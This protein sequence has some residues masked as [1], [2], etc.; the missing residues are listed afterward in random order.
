VGAAALATQ[1]EGEREAGFTV[2][3][4]EWVPCERGQFPTRQGLR[5]RTDHDVGTSGE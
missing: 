4:K 3:L 2:A 5:H 1:R